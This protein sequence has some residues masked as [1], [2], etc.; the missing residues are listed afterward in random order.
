MNGY[1]YNLSHTRAKSNADIILGDGENKPEASHLSLG[2]T[3]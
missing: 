3:K 1:P 2:E